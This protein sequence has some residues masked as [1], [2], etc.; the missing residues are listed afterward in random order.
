MARRF[1]VTVGELQSANPHVLR[2][3]DILRPGDRLLVPRGVSIEIGSK[4]EYYTVQ[5]GDSWGAI[6]AQFSIPLRLLQTVNSAI[7]RPYSILQ[8]GDKLFIP[9]SDQFAGAVR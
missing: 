4:G 9:Q 5:A 6:A 2:G 8:P 7:V 3:G 1:N